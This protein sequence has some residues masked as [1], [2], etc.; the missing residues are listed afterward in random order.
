MSK[1]DKNSLIFIAPSSIVNC[2][3]VGHSISSVSSEILLNE[4]FIED[5]DPIDAFVTD[6]KR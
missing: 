5:A 6:E 1:D 4:N 3:I 2:L